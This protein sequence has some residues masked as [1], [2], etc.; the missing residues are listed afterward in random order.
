MIDSAVADL[1]EPDSPTIASVSP[2]LISND[3]R[4]TAITSRSPWRNAMERSST[5][6]NDVPVMSMGS[7]E[8]LARVE[9]VAHRL[10]DEDQERQHDGN[11]EEAGETEPGRLDV[12]LA[13]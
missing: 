4:S 1:P 8:R 2:F 5:L 9:G 10:A 12:G 7:P 3:M 13:L 11:R 6:S